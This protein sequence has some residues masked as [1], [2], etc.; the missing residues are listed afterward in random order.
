[1]DTNFLIDRNGDPIILK[2]K[3]IQDFFEILKRD[4]FF[5]SKE[6]LIDYSL[7]LVLD[8]EHNIAFIKIIDYLRTYDLI[9]NFENKWKTFRNTKAPPTI[10]EPNK[11][12]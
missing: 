10:M 1:M 12:R 9:K 5:L 11:Y 8:V 4:T 3:K 6:L 2:G 7:L